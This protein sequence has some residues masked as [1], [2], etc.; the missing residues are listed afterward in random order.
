MH[1]PLPKYTVLDTLIPL[2]CHFEFSRH[3]PTRILGKIPE[4]VPSGQ[5]A[6]L[7]SPATGP[8]IVALKHDDRRHGQHNNRENTGLAAALLR[9]SAFPQARG[10]R[11][12]PRSP[13]RTSRLRIRLRTAPSKGDRNSGGRGSCRA[14]SILPARREARPPGG[15]PG[16]FCAAR[17]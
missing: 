8:A 14:S 11:T 5:E 7:G 2:L 17:Y 9:W 10:L 12:L 4:P 6:A 3:E 1:H 13:V 15:I 16:F